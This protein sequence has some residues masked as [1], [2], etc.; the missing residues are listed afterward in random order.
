MIAAPTNMP[1][2]AK[3]KLRGSV[4]GARQWYLPL[5]HGAR[6]WA[7]GQPFG[8][9]IPFFPPR[10]VSCRFGILRREN[11]WLLFT[12]WSSTLNAVLC[13]S[14]VGPSTVADVYRQAST[15]D[16]SLVCIF[17]FLWGSGTMCF[18]LGIQLVRAGSSL[19]A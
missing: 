11:V 13:L 2:G 4:N 15:A 9:T 10:A 1:R 3:P 7:R 17:A 19:N 16:L 18:S 5:G 6:D 12:L 8:L 14:V